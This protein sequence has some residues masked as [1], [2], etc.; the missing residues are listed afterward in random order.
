[1]SIASKNNILILLG[2]IVIGVFVEYISPKIIP[3]LTLNP[4]RTNT[5][6]IELSELVIRDDIQEIMLKLENYTPGKPGY[7]PSCGVTKKESC[8]GEIIDEDQDRY[9]GEIKNEDYHGIG[10][11]TGEDFIVVASWVDGMISGPGVHFSV[12]IKTKNTEILFQG[13]FKDDDY[14]QGIEYLLDGAIYEGS[15]QE[16]LHHGEGKLTFDDMSYYEG[17]FYKGTYHGQGTFD[18]GESGGKYVGEWSYG[19][20]QGRGTQFYANGNIYKG[21]WKDG[22]RHGQGSYLYNSGDKYVGS[23]SYGNRHGTGTYTYDG[24]EEYS[25]NFHFGQLDGQIVSI[26]P[27]GEKNICF[28]KKDLLEGKCSKIYSSGTMEVC[29]F[30][31]GMKHGECKT[32]FDNGAVVISNYNY[33]VKEG[34]AIYK[35][36]EGADENCDYKGGRRHGICRTVYLTGHVQVCNYDNGIEIECNWHDEN[37]ISDTIEP[38]AKIGRGQGILYDGIFNELGSLKTRVEEALE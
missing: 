21:Q 15:F 2:A 14:Y 9:I 13:D 6:Q 17:E 10:T 37:N 19:L 11:L 35:F 12:D 29:N 27:D 8:Y 25:G 26:H 4:T 18:Y 7:L 38:K 20:E 30:S 24:G 22:L 28:Y 23:H 34:K 33:G 32:T 1:M 36:A 16:F 31:G 3:Y 5:S